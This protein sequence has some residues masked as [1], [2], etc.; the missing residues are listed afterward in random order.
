MNCRMG[1]GIA[2]DIDGFVVH[3]SI[4][5][6]RVILSPNFVLSKKCSDSRS[7]VR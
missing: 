1:S 3:Q 5:R 6:P 7:D 2:R 4:V